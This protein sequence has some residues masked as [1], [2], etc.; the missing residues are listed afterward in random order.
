MKEQFGTTTPTYHK[1]F[2]NSRGQLFDTRVSSVNDT[3]DW[4]RGRLILYYSSNHLWG[5]AGSDNNGNVRFAETW[6]PPENATLDQADTVIEQSYNYDSLN[7]LTSVAEQRMTAAGGWV[8]SQ[9]FQQSYNYDRWGNRTIN[10][11]SWGTGIN[12]KQFTVNTVNNRLGVPVG[13]PAQ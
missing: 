11:A 7:R 5:Q 6:I 9:Q 8:W 2:H 3:W 10:P 13:Q 1:L 12:V 4:N